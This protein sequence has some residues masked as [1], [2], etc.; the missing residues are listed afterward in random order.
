MA[1]YLPGNVPADAAELAAFLRAELDKIAQALDAPDAA[2]AL[3]TLYAAPAKYRKG[4]IVRA[5]GTTWNPGA[6]A[7]PYEYSGAAWVK[8]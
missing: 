3:D 2:L 1:R 8:L 5:D 7:G 4:T 6:G